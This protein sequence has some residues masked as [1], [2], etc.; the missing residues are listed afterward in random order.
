MIGTTLAQCR[1]TGELGAGGMGKV[2]RVDNTHVGRRAALEGIPMNSRFC[3]IYVVLS[4][5]T[6]FE[7]SAALGADQ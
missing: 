2:W 4:Q 1:I 3:R 5:S 6:E 7:Q